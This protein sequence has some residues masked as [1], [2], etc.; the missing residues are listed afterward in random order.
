VIDTKIPQADQFMAL[1]VIGLLGLTLGG[2]FVG[3]HGL[4][5][6]PS[7][8]LIAGALALLGALFLVGAVLA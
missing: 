7:I 6:W 5:P 8:G 4:R 2:Y 3:Q 1:L